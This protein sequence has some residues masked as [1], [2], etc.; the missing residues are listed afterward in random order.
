MI[1]KNLLS[2]AYYYDKLPLMFKNSYGIGDQLKIFTDFINN[3]DNVAEVLFK[4]LDIRDVEMS[5]SDK[6]PN[7][8]VVSGSGKRYGDNSKPNYVSETNYVSEGN[9][10]NVEY[11]SEGE[12]TWNGIHLSETLNPSNNAILDWIGN[13][14]GVKRQFRIGETYIYLGNKEFIRLIKAQ[15]LQNNYAGTREQI[16]ELYSDLGLT[17]RQYNSTNPGEVYLYWD[18]ADFRN[19][20]GTYKD[21]FSANDK[22]LFEHGFY[23]IKSMGLS[24]HTEVVN[25]KN[26]GIWDSEEKLW[27]KTYTD[28]EK[29]AYWD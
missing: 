26:L 27:G 14:V 20:D 22:I 7:L 12:R 24:Y 29:T 23:T 19:D 1:K 8:S 11:G 18:K 2:W 6:V 4:M 16:N 15:I 28:E 5:E 17:I 9:I 25:F 13:L 10:L 3:C 21:G